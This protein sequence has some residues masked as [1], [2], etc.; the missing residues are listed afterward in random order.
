M[1][2]RLSTTTGFAVGAALLQAAA[3]A[4]AQET[5]QEVYDAYFLSHVGGVALQTYPEHIAATTLVPH[6]ARILK[7][8]PDLAGKWSEAETRAAVAEFGT[9]I[10][11]PYRARFTLRLMEQLSV[12]EAKAATQ[13]ASDPA[14]MKAINC[15]AVKPGR[16]AADWAAC[17]GDGARALS[18]DEQALAT[19]SLAALNG[20]LANPDLNST[21]VGIVCHVL[22]RFS[23][24]MSTDGF[25]RKFSMTI[26]VL[27]AENAI[28]CDRAKPRYASLIGH[29][30]YL[31][32]EPKLSFESDK[33]D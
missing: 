28:A 13:I 22:D 12:A 6:F 32:L 4:S 24:R 10:R 9:P 5:P 33:K 2:L 1:T 7:D 23:D 25:T 15:V 26:S 19:K 17:T 30:M 21:T 18:P 14:A 27:E 8:D 31:R 11:L 20:A 16:A 3:P 29:D